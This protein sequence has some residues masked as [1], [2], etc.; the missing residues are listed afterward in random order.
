M[1][2][3]RIHRGSRALYALASYISPGLNTRL[4][5]LRKFGRLPELEAPKTLNEKLLKLKLERY[6]TDPLVRQC[7]DK[8]RVRSYVEE[9]GCAETLN[10]LYA[11]YDRADDIDWNSLPQS[12]AM[13]WSFGCGY[14]IICPDKAALNIP[15]AEKQLK[16]WGREPFWAYY[17]E[18]QYRHAE[19][20]IIIE[21]YI[22]DKDGKLPEDYK[23]YLDLRKYGTARHAGFG[24]GF[25]RCVMYLTG[26]SNIRD[27]LPF[28][29]TVNNCDL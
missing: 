8:Y 6:G 27:V 21:E 25:E 28:P 13:K 3:K 7:A 29:R 4:L 14:N 23:F 17:S 2:K 12:F 9:R 22:G 19:K 10:K 15:A 24:L 20:K 11:V 26:I 1:K 5:Y 18:M 16:K